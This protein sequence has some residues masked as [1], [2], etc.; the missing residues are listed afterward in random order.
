MSWE[1]LKWGKVIKNSKIPKYLSIFI[2]IYAITI[3]P[4]IIFSD[5]GNVVTLNHERIH[6][7]QQLELLVVGFYFLYVIF[8]LI[9]LLKNIKSQDRFQLAYSYIPFEKEA[10]ANE[11]EFIYI[12]HRKPYSW[13]EYIGDKI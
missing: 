2:N 12:L 1:E 3:F 13:I 7:R 8:W 9:G 11:K 6:I 5:K 4:F 10:Y